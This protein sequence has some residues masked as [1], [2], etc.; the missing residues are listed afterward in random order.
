[1]PFAPRRFLDRRAADYFIDY[2]D[3]Q[4]TAD[5]M[6]I[7][8]DVFAEKQE[9][10]QAVV[11]VDGTARPQVVRANTNPSYY[12]ILEEFEKRTGIGCI[13][14]TSFNMHEEPI[15]HSPEDALRAFDHGSV[16]VL[17]MGNYIVIQRSD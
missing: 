7:T 9:E 14:N 12:R 11:H 6:T 16:D 3:A 8:Y 2:Q 10:I 4:V 13:I 15:V 1:M 5:W 17:A